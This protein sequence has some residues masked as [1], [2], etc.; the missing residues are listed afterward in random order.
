MEAEQ[1]PGCV[2]LAGEAHDVAGRAVGPAH[3][4]HDRRFAFEGVLERGGDIVGFGDS[5]GG[6][7]GGGR[8]TIRKPRHCHPAAHPRVGLVGSWR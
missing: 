2:G 3:L 4:R 8:R 6:R 7:G 1:D 5:R